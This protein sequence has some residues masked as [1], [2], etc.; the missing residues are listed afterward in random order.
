M[1]ILRRR[2]RRNGDYAELALRLKHDLKAH[3]IF[4]RTIEDI[5]FFCLVSTEQLRL[6]EILQ[7]FYLFP[8]YKT[9]N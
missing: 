3:Y 4:S 9:F 8:L 2:F 6:Y 5:Y 7:N 1:K